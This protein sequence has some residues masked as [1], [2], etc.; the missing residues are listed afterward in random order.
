MVI[1]NNNYPP[2]SYIGCCFCKKK[3]YYRPI[4]SPLIRSGLGLEGVSEFDIIREWILFNK[5]HVVK[6]PAEGCPIY[7]HA[8]FTKYR[9][10]LRIRKQYGPIKDLEG[11]L[12]SYKKFVNISVY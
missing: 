2:L 4:L 11:K 5:W 3:L 9:K 12:D 10:K 6:N 7:C 8:C 1:V